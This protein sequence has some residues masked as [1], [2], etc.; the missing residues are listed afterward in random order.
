MHKVNLSVEV[1]HYLEP[2]RFYLESCPN[3]QTKDAES[4]FHG[5][6]YECIDKGGMFRCTKCQT[7]MN[8]VTYNPYSIPMSDIHVFSES[9]QIL[10]QMKEFLTNFN[11]LNV[12]LDIFFTK[13]TLEQL[14]LVSQYKKLAI[15]NYNSPGCENLPTTIKFCEYDFIFEHFDKFSVEDID[16]THEFY[17]TRRSKLKNE[18]SVEKTSDL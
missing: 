4:S 9:E 5:S 11:G 17:D 12:D 3:C 18:I 16:L 15:Y 13:F 1:D 2:V 14:K 10:A 6:P 7:L 8:L